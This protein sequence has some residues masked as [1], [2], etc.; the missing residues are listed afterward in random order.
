MKITNISIIKS[1]N[2]WKTWKANS[3]VLITVVIPA[4][5][6]PVIALYNIYEYAY[7][8]RYMYTSNRNKHYVLRITFDGQVL[9]FFIK[10]KFNSN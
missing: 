10:E 5:Y 1:C 4:K 6:K 2:S 7:L 9:L 8:T 3:Y